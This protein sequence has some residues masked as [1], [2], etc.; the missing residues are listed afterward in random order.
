MSYFSGMGPRSV[1]AAMC[2]VCLAYCGCRRVVLCT[3]I[4][5][6]DALSLDVQGLCSIFCVVVKTLFFVSL[7]L[8]RIHSVVDN[9]RSSLFPHTYIVLVL[10]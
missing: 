4:I 6:N 3:F 5:F 10:L 2:G 7:S 1:V 8:S 9:S